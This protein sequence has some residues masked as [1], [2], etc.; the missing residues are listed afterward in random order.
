MNVF[1]F[2]GNLGRDVEVR[3]VSGTTVANFTVAAKSGFGQNEQTIWVDCALWGKRAEGKLVEYLTKGQ[4]VAVSGEIGTRTYQK[5]DGSNGF[6]ITCRVGD[7]TLMGDKGD[8]SV[9][10]TSQGTQQPQ[11]T[12]PATQ[13]QGGIASSG[14]WDDEVPF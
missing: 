8:S 12:K 7:V 3:D 13:P 4:K 14:D 1:C 6:A 9:P 5:Q 11:D 10:S 2:T